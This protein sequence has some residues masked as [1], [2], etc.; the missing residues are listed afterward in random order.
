MRPFERGPRFSEESPREKMSKTERTG[1][2]DDD[3]ID[4]AVKTPVLKT[5]VENEEIRFRV[6]PEDLVPGLKTIG[7]LGVRH[8]RQ[9]ALQH[10]ELVVSVGPSAVASTED[11]GKS[12]PSKPFPSQRFDQGCLTGAPRCDVP[13]GE[14]RA[15]QTARPK[16]ASSPSLDVLSV[17]PDSDG[18]EGFQDGEQ[19]IDD[20]VFRGHGV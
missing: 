10:L 11:C 9:A 3:D 13:H 7:V 4:I 16:A 1:R 6:L 5:V 18:I 2:I 20:I 17:H 15:W 19:R 8:A 14:D 12:S